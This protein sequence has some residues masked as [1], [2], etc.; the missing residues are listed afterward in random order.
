MH[1]LICA[2]TEPGDLILD[3]FSGS[4]TVSA[5]ALLS[6]RCSVAIDIDANYVK[7]AT[8]RLNTLVGNSLLKKRQ[9]QQQLEEQ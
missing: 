4:G 9:Q 3:L 6:N 8:V 7:A 5:S 2:Y 1:S